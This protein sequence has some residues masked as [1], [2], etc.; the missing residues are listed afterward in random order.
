[1]SDRLLEATLS[2]Q[3]RDGKSGHAEFLAKLEGEKKRRSEKQKS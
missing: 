1:M 3:K 2:A